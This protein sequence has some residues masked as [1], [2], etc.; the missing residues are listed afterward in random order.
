MPFDP[1][2]AALELGTKIIERVWK[3]P[4]Q[5]DAA[6]L[7]LLKL[8]QAGELQKVA[9]QME[10]NKAEA[11][12]QSVFVAG[13]RPFIGWVCGSALAFQFIARPLIAWLSALFGHAV[14]PPALDM[15]DLFTL[16]F[17][18]LGLGA[19]RSFDKAQGTDSGH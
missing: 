3:D 15:G 19:M 16:L 17:G 10:I 13:W 12:N 4:A 14:A 18:M 1:I 6:K 11:T 8:Q 9:G 7:E 2:S 5:Q